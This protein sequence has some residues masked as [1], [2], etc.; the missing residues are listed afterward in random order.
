MQ[1]ILLL[2]A[3]VVV[4]ASAQHNSTLQCHFCESDETPECE[5]NTQDVLQVY[6]KDLD[7][8]NSLSRSGGQKQN[9]ILSE[10]FQRESSRALTAPQITDFRCIAVEVV[11]NNRKNFIRT[12]APMRNNIENACDFIKEQVDNTINIRGCRECNDDFCN[13]AIPL[14]TSL[15]LQLASAALVWFLVKL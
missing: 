3:V 1:K 5:K 7:Y 12:C 6:C 15:I 2:V 9:K 11:E 4:V 10:V 13:S 14:G 8:G